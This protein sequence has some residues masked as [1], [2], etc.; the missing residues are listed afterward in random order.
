MAVN[1]SAKLERRFV[2]TMNRLL[3]AME[4]AVSAA[5]TPQE[6]LQLLFLY[7]QSNDYREWCMKLATKITTQVHTIVN[8]TWREAAAKAGKGSRI[9][10][11]IMRD[12]KSPIGGYG[13]FWSKLRENAELIT[14]FPKDVS[15]HLNRYIAAEA[16]KGRRSED[17][18]RDLIKKF[19][20]E[21]KS[22]L[23]L[24]ARTEV[25][26]TQTALI[27][28]RAMSLG[29]DWYI[30]RTSDDERVRDSHRKMNGVICSWKD[31]PDP[32]KL[33][34]AKSYGKYHAGDIFN[35]RCYPEP[36]V[37]LDYVKFPAKVYINGTIRT[38]SRKQFEK[39]A[40]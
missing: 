34:G 28:S 4:K 37:N 39:L 6:A 21:S 25:S 33:I 17:I 20:D 1:P 5:R 2:Y 15:I 7:S 27:Q 35:C 10:E 3:R 18:L 9:Y 12:L 40:A 29:A 11:D 22:R 13:H 8:G 26:K 14:K 32:E 19:P 38:M 30:W 16:L 24:I 31:P 36:I 23:K